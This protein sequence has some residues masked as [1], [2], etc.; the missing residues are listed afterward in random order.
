MR[1]LRFLVIGI[2]SVMLVG[3]S[4]GQKGIMPAAGPAKEVT[5]ANNS[6]AEV[7]VSTPEQADEELTQLIL[8]VEQ[9]RNELPS[10]GDF[11]AIPTEQ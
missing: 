3:C 4:S 8:E 7:V 6:T 5:T 2:L 10:G 11:D 1:Y 9:L